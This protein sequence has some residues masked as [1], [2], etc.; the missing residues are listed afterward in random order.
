MGILEDL[1][2]AQRETIRL[3]ED[4][5]R[6]ERL[7]QEWYTAA[8]CARLKGVSHAFLTVNRWARPLGGAGVKK[9][10]GRPRWHRNAVKEW[11][12]QDDAELKS[13]YGGGHPAARPLSSRQANKERSSA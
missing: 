13:L 8:D 4:L 11:L 12:A 2:E 5:A 6:T 9:I 7:G 1:A 10:S 3:L